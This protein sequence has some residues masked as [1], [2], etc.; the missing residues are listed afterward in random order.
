MRRLTRAIIILLLL[1]LAVA[2]YARPGEAEEQLLIRVYPTPVGYRVEFDRPVGEIAGVYVGGNYYKYKTYSNGTLWVMYGFDE[3]LTKQY[4]RVA[5]KPVEI[6][7]PFQ[8]LAL[9]FPGRNTL[10]LVST[11]NGLFYS[12]QYRL[13]WGG[14]T[15][16]TPRDGDLVISNTIDATVKERVTYIVGITSDK[17][18]ITV[19]LPNLTVTM[20]VFQL[21]NL[22]SSCIAFY[23][24]PRMPFVGG[25]LPSRL[26]T[27]NYVPVYRYQYQGVNLTVAVKITVGGKPVFVVFREVD[28]DTLKNLGFISPVT[29]VSSQHLAKVRA[30]GHIYF[31]RDGVLHPVPVKT[32]LDATTVEGGKHTC[33]FPPRYNITFQ[34]L[35]EKRL[36]GNISRYELL[37]GELILFTRPNSNSTYAC[38]GSLDYLDVTFPTVSTPTIKQFHTPVIV[39]SSK[40]IVV[41][42]SDGRAFHGKEIVIPYSV[43][44][45]NTLIYITSNPQ[46]IRFEA[47]SIFYTPNFWVALFL[48]A[49]IARLILSKPDTGDFTVKIILSS[50][51]PDPP[52]PA[53]KDVVEERVKQYIHRHGYCPYKRELLMDGV[54]LPIE[55]GEKPGDRVLVCPFKVN[56]RAEYIFRR[57]GEMMENGFWA[58]RRDIEK[59]TSYAYTLIGG[60]ALVLFLY[61]QEFEKTPEKLVK[62]A[63]YTAYR[64]KV[65]LPYHKEYVGLAIIA[66]PEVAEQVKEY[67]AVNGIVDVDGDVEKWALLNPTNLFASESESIGT[68]IEFMNTAI[69]RIIVVSKPHE[70]VEA[71]AP[72][73]VRHYKEYVRVFRRGGP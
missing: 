8:Y 5:V 69:P 52:K 35:W 27:G 59:R 63:I 32:V 70:V 34:M 46:R 14:Y 19:R 40:E 9:Q 10:L 43:Y 37:P 29:R 53:P 44:R 4:G 62:R 16:S 39:K 54:F 50:Y 58:V 26:C 42:S 28:V 56:R 41:M 38:V 1:A 24:N 48:S 15:T 20:N 36:E 22:S 66:E 18:K 71:L 31:Y 13:V 49:V 33:Y 21:L 17:D 72:I 7:R 45:K 25:I 6:Y 55:P 51:M 23:D 64:T 61:K 60:K 30:A 73:V 68:I 47:R 57:V 65:I 11:L 67:L 3:L 12:S 2:P